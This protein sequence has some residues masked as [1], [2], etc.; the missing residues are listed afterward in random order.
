MDFMLATGVRLGVW[1]PQLC[2]FSYQSEWG[3]SASSWGREGSW[4]PATGVGMVCVPETIRLILDQ[5]GESWQS[6]YQKGRMV[7]D[8]RGT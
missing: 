4:P 5:G 1:V 2:G 6:K 8:R 3:L 7:L